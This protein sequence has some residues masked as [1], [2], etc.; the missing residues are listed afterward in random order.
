MLSDKVEYDVNTEFEDN[1]FKSCFARSVVVNSQ[2][3]QEQQLKRQLQNVG[4]RPNR[5]QVTPFVPQTNSKECFAGGHYVS[6][7][8]RSSAC[9]SRIAEMP[10]ENLLLKTQ[11]ETLQWQL[12]QTES[13]K[14]MYKEV[15]TQ[16]VKF[17]E[18]AYRSLQILGSKVPSNSSVLRAQSDYHMN[19]LLDSTVDQRRSTVPAIDALPEYTA[20]RD[21]TRRQK[22]AQQPPD[23]IPPEKLSQEAFR[24][25]RTAQ[26]LLNTTAPDLAQL[27]HDASEDLK[28]LE[29]LA[30]EFPRTQENGTHRPAS[31]C[32]S[33]LQ[34]CAPPDRDIR[35]STAFNR[36]LSLHHSKRNS[37]HLEMLPSS[38]LNEDAQTDI[39]N[40]KFNIEK[41]SPALSSVSSAEDESGFSSMN[42]F[43]ELGIPL[44]NSTVVEEPKE[45][46]TKTDFQLW[47]T[48]ENKRTPTNHKRWNSTPT[49]TDK[50]LK[51]LWV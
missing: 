40:R 39:K 4:I 48:P 38:T 27:N 41:S 21:F 2:H 5:D 51:V 19:Q 20:F 10:I 18:R 11:I 3:Q 44:T 26:S 30:K 13:S 36:K 12:K 28:F 50:P 29:Q 35:I 37:F 25:L 43:Q 47:Q 7:S 22:K 17:L 23:E 14:E 6:D 32:S 9:S 45:P 15:M 8:R 31:R 33:S 1:N 42:S 49:D 24:L 16:V 46:C 34:I